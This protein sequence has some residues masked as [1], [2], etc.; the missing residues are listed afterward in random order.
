VPTTGFTVAMWVK[1]DLSA[2]TAD[3]DR[4][5]LFHAYST[6]GKGAWS[7]TNTGFGVC[8][9][10]IKPGSTTT[11]Q[12]RMV[13]REFTSSSTNTALG[14]LSIDA[15]IASNEWIHFAGTYDAS[16][17]TMAL[18]INGVQIGT[19]ATNG[20]A[21]ANDWSGGSQI[22]CVVDGY[23]R[24]FFGDIDEF[25]IFNRALTQA[26]ITKLATSHTAALTPGDANGD[27][28]VDVGDLGILAANYGGADKTWSQGDFNGDGKVDV[29]DLGILAANY[30]KNASGA[31]FNAD[32]AKVFGTTAADT[33]EEDTT[34]STSTLC[35]GLGLSLIAGLA[36]LGLMLVKLEE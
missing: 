23:A 9:V 29:G 4:M 33:T 26:E 3:N 31:D 27:N 22:G 2:M 14:D 30:G 5:E 11:Y 35:S 25:Y 36:M 32:Y 19:L 28:K 8:Q 21:M 24:Q 7:S 16:A 6:Y 34:D 15:D 17:K 12:W 1:A 13:L 10:E 18:Y 20:D